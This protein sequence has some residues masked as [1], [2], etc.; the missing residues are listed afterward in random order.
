MVRLFI[1]VLISLAFG[2]QILYCADRCS[3]QQ[4]ICERYAKALG[5]THE[6]LMKTIVNEVVA[7]ELASPVIKPFF[8]G[9]LPAGSTDFTATSNKAAFDKLAAGLVAFFGGALGCSEAG[10]PKYTGADMEVSVFQF[11]DRK[12][13]ERFQFIPCFSFDRVDII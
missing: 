5:V 2:T 4:T 11:G 1:L 3:G 10:F 7:Q 6:N 9:R 12:C 8:D 13:T